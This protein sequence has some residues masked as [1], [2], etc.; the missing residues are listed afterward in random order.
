M[1]SVTS[2]TAENANTVV[3]SLNVDVFIPGTKRQDPLETGNVTLRRKKGQGVG[4]KVPDSG[5]DRILWV[6][7]QVLFHTILIYDVH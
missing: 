1:P 7:L 2:S 3:E 5:E 4:E 6:L